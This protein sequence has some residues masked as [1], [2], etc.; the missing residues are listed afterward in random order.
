[1]SVEKRYSKRYSMQGDVYI[2][3]R[4]QRA[5]PAKAVDCSLYGMSLKTENLTLI[6][7]AMVELDIYFQERKWEIVGLVTHTK[8]N[9]LG[10]M[11]WDP[12]PELYAEVIATSAPD[13]LEDQAL[14]TNS[15]VVGIFSDKQPMTR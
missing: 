11:F 3:Y 7:G 13:S 2:R 5:F 10:V 15:Q 8:K 1:M 6:S 12:Q 14:S 9:G 4:K